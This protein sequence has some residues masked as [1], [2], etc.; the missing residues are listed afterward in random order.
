MKPFS[1]NRPIVKE[2]CENAKKPG[3]VFLLFCLWIIILVSRPQDIFPALGVLRPALLVGM[4]T[5][6]T[7]VLQ[8]IFFKRFH[9]LRERQVK[10]YIAL[11]GIMILGIPFSLYT[12]LSFMT[13][14]TLYINVII[15]F[16]MFVVIVDSVKKLSFVLFLGCLSNGFYSA[17]AVA[18]G[19]VVSGRLMFGEMFDPN[20]L[21]FFT[22]CFLSINLLYISRDNRLLVRLACLGCVGSGLLLILLTGSRGGMLAL[23]VVSILLIFRKSKVVGKSLKVA[24]IGLALFFIGFSTINFERFLTVFELNEDYNTSAEDGRLKVWERGMKIMLANPLT[25]VGVDCFG[26]A[27][28]RDREAEGARTLMW[29]APHNMFVQ[30]GTETGVIGFSLYLLITFNVFIILN[31]ARKNEYSQQLSRIGEM[32][33]LGFSGLVISGFF[34][35]QAYS[36]Y[37]AFYVALSSVINRLMNNQIKTPDA[38]PR[39]STDG[40]R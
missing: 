12:R 36:M 1:L 2:P 39:M 22:L 19:Q 35:S 27:I 25:G 8:G 23:C 26:E 33:F 11:L 16:F 17:F 6:G 29:Q 15:F 14:F 18:K 40:T 13:V 10:L 24:M 7:A 34:L 38:P 31:K 28:G 4:V 30:I 37:W 9:F 21:A 32:T 3:V 5:L 20:D